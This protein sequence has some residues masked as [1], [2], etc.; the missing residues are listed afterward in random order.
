MSKTGAHSRD[1]APKA[2][3]GARAAPR[4]TPTRCRA[5]F[6]RVSRDLRPRAVSRDAGPEPCGPAC[7]YTDDVLVNYIMLV[8]HTAWYA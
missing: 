8:M 5:G 7:A 1:C 3:A 2:A 6:G 4:D